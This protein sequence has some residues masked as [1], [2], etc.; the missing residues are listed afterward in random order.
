M[1]RDLGKN[2]GEER[3]GRVHRKSQGDT[4][5]GEPLRWRVTGKHERHPRQSIGR[6]RVK[7]YTLL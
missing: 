3:P 2:S 6:S 7:K 1:G 5:L 4:E